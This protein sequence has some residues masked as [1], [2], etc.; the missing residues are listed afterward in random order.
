MG[1][2]N[3]KAYYTKNESKVGTRIVVR[4]LK[5]AGP[6]SEGGNRL[7]SSILS[8]LK[9]VHDMFKKSYPFK[10]VIK[11]EYLMNDKLYK[12]FNDRKRRFRREGRNARETL[13]FHGTHPDNIKRFDTRKCYPD[14]RITSDGLC[15]GGKNGHKVANGSSM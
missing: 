6:P 8:Q 14:I 4:R 2:H 10:E 9:E 3:S 15:R 7:T 11:I 5:P 1:S 12:G 13:L